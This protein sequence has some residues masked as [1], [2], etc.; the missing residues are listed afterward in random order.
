MA[1]SVEQE[2]DETVFEG[3]YVIN[4]LAPLDAIFQGAREIQSR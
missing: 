3:S 1:L 4:H 2:Q